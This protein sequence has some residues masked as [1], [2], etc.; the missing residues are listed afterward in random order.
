MR[1]RVHKVKVLL[2]TTNKNFG[3]ITPTKSL[4]LFDFKYIFRTFR[5]TQLLDEQP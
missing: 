3:V 5:L 4:Q 1:N 2:V